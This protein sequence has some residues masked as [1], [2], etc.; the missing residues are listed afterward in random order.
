MLDAPLDILMMLPFLAA[1]IA[2][3]KARQGRY[4]DFTLRSKEKSQSDSEQSRIVPW[5][6]KPAQLKRMSM[7]P[8]SAAREFTA[9]MSR[10][11]RTRVLIVGLA[12]SFLRRSSLMSVARTC[13]PSRAKA[14][15]VAAPIPWPAAVIK[16]VF[17]WR[18]PVV[19]GGIGSLSL[20]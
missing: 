2:G 18:R 14:E 19:T 7:A 4:I 3:M 8:S 15:V 9:L 20:D 16:A 17:P 1:A 12:A 10:T 13:A 5:W 11:S 6:T